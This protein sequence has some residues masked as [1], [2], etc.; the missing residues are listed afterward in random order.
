MLV[1]RIY[2]HNLFSISCGAARA[3][4]ARAAPGACVSTR[5]CGKRDSP[6]NRSVY[7]DIGAP[8]TININPSS[9]RDRRHVAP[10]QTLAVHSASDSPALSFHLPPSPTWRT[11]RTS[12]YTAPIQDPTMCQHSNMRAQLSQ[13]KRA[14]VRCRQPS[15][16]IDFSS[17]FMPLSVVLATWPMSRMAASVA[18]APSASTAGGM[19][20]P[21][22]VRSGGVS[23][24]G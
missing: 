15:D 6:L 16:Q 2:R 1:K 3:A 9:T 22:P 20:K 5:V 8:R 17:S 4:G 24:G 18:A 19:R 10:H 21:L 14:P 11:D 23:L 7:A 13:A 12:G